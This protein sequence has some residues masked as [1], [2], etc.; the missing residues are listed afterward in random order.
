MERFLVFKSTE[1]FRIEIDNRRLEW[2]AY[3]IVD[4]EP[5]FNYQWPR[6]VDHGGR[7]RCRR[8]TESGLADSPMPTLERRHGTRTICICNSWSVSGNA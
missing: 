4:V 3:A 1:S 5:R 6:I 7:L 2:G 8:T